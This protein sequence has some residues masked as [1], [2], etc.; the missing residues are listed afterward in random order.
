V[1]RQLR[2]LSTRSVS[3]TA[4]RKDVH[5]SEV[6][7]D[8]TEF[9]RELRD[10]W[11]R[12]GRPHAREM[13]WRVQVPPTCFRFIF[14][15]VTELP[16]FGDIS[17]FLRAVGERTVT[18]E[19]W[20]RRWKALKRREPVRHAGTPADPSRALLVDHALTAQSPDEFVAHLRTLK[21]LSGMSFNDIAV[22]TNMRLP[23]STGHWL[24]TP[25]NF[26]TRVE[27]IRDLVEACGA[28][29]PETRRWLTAY[30]RV[31]QLQRI[32]LPSDEPRDLE[33]IGDQL[34]GQGRHSEAA[35]VYKEALRLLM[36]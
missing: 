21:E 24:L 31:Q 8:V 6:K 4:S 11:N 27:Q 15:E 12:A 2:E 35:T 18:V 32:P 19:K 25:G 13:G 22:A 26:P 33:R 20:Q 16:K 14:H 34:A 23:K 28:T 17:V 30:E 36:I 7:T 1:G 29:E 5:V 3:P 10:L 9:V